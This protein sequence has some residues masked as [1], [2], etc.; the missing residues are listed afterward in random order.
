MLVLSNKISLRKLETTET[1]PTSK[2]IPYT[3]ETQEQRFNRLAAYYDGS[4]SQN[5]FERLKATNQ[6]GNLTDLRIQAYR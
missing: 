4:N 3:E 5:I 6:Y 1:S 2:C